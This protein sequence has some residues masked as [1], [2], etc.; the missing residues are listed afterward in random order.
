MWDV[1]RLELNVFAFTRN[2]HSL[3]VNVKARV[4]GRKEVFHPR[5]SLTPHPRS[6][7]SPITGSNLLS[8][9]ENRR[10]QSI[11][12]VLFNSLLH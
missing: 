12:N 5:L 7:G 3:G 6:R 1:E 2:R 8:V 9:G 4:R 11:K 10:V